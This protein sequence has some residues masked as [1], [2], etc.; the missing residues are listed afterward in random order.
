MP[1]GG[2]CEFLVSFCPLKSD[3]SNG[4]ISIVSNAGTSPDTIAVSGNGLLPQQV[5][6]IGQWGSIL[7]VVLM[8]WGAVAAIK[9]IRAE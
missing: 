1:A 7:L 9:R 6:T 8:L 4:V 2:S 3:S 5:P